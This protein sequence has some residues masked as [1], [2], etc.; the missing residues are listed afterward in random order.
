MSR[1]KKKA[2]NTNNQYK[3]IFEERGVNR[4]EQSRT[5]TLKE[6]PGTIPTFEY[7]W[8]Y[9]DNFAISYGFTCGSYDCGLAYTD[10]SDDGYGADEDAFVFS[11]SASL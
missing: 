10:F 5:P 9:G 2:V 8:K 11:V 6:V 7:V 1:N 3:E 4:I